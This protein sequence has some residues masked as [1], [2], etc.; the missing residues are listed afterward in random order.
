MARDITIQAPAARLKGAA[1]NPLEVPTPEELYQLTYAALRD[2]RR[3]NEQLTD[4]ARQTA[5]IALALAKMIVDSGH[6]AVSED[7]ITI[8]RWLHEQMLGA[9]ITVG[10]T[11]AGEPT[12][13]IVERGRQRLHVA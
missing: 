2:E 5:S 4:F 1:P 13:R 6:P 9:S 11:V 8:P 12:V 7:T 3:K 10:Q